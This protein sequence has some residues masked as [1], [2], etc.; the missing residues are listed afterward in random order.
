MVRKGGGAVQN[1]GAKAAHRWGGSV[2]PVL[3]KNHIISG[4]GGEGGKRGTVLYPGGALNRTKGW[5]ILKLKKVGWRSL[6]PT[7]GPPGKS[8]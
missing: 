6:L 1:Y 5:H 3:G 7:R 2:Q 8:V 4:G